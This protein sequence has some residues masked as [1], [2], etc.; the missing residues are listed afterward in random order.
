MTGRI[1][2][3]MS[4]AELAELL[5]ACKPQPMIMLQCGPPPSP[6]ECANSA[7]ARLGEHLNFDY[8]T[9]KPVPGKGKQFFTAEP[10]S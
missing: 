1:L 8:M 4:E 10:T 2:Y 9:V 6:Q 5:D 3:E 7:W